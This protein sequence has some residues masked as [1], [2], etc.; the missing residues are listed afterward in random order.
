MWRRIYLG[1][2]FGTLQLAKLSLSRCQDAKLD[3][4]IDIDDQVAPSDLDDIL[5]FLRSTHPRPVQT[6]SVRIPT[7]PEKPPE[8]YGI[9]LINPSYLEEFEF[10]HSRCWRSAMLPI[11]LPTSP[12]LRRLTLGGVYPSPTKGFTF[13]SLTF[14]HLENTLD[15]SWLGEEFHETLHQFPNLEEIHFEMTDFEEDLSETISLTKIR[16]INFAVHPVPMSQILQ[17]LDAPRLDTVAFSD[18]GH[19]WDTGMTRQ[20]A[21]SV[22]VHHPSVRLLE[23]KEDCMAFPYDNT[24]FL[25]PQVLRSLEVINVHYSA[26]QLIPR[27][28]MHAKQGGWTSLW[29]NLK[30]IVIVGKPRKPEEGHEYAHMIDCLNVFAKGRNKIPRADGEAPSPLSIVFQLPFAWEGWAKTSIQHLCGEVARIQIGETII[31]GALGEVGAEK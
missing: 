17:Y 8:A 30:D 26:G 3:I 10:F 12:L 22:T 13:E 16:R 6:F 5:S 27:T 4:K 9:D 25:L 2:T 23:L 14:L 20:A 29:D 28:V 31:E 7:N 19:R 15:R 18:P 11:T 24:A 21:V 1:E